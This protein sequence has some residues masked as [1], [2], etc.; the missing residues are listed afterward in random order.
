MHVRAEGAREDIEGV[1]ASARERWVAD[2]W[3]DCPLLRIRVRGIV[4]M[5]GGGDV[6]VWWCAGLV[7]WKF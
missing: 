2:W 6:R 4:A 3:E 5:R 7:V 1:D